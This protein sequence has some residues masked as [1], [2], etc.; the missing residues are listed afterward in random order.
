MKT[1][2]SIQFPPNLE[3]EEAIENME[4]NKESKGKEK[5]EMEIEDDFPSRSQNP[6]ID[7]KK[8]IREAALKRLE[9]PISTLIEGPNNF[10]QQQQQQ[11]ERNKQE[12]EQEQEMRR[13]G[14]DAINNALRATMMEALA[15]REN[16][17]PQNIDEFSEKKLRRNQVKSLQLF[18]LETVANLLPVKGSY[19]PIKS[20][21]GIG[22]L[23]G[24]KILH[25]L[26]K[27]QTLDFHTLSKLAP[28]FSIFSFLFIYLFIYL[29]IL[30][31]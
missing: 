10:N 9:D 31:S 17:V 11:D 7:M 30:I 1:P 22:P 8:K 3:K 6:S 20:L 29:S 26:M 25:L 27:N 28:R 23:L 5:I 13:Q 2:E 14:Q 15:R 24:N 4:V 18:A 12:V 19:I 16:I 21:K